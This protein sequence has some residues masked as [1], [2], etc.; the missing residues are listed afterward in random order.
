MLSPDPSKPNQPLTS[1]EH[2]GSD[3]VVTHS[4]VTVGQVS[5]RDK[6]NQTLFEIERHSLLKRMPWI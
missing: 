5:T 1:V 6:V 4:H 2:G 3:V